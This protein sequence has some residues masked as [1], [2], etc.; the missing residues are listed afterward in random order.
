M[1]KEIW[2]G[3]L[4]GFLYQDDP[5]NG[6]LYIQSPVKAS[7]DNFKIEHNGIINPVSNDDELDFSL[8]INPVKKANGKRVPRTDVT[9]CKK[10]ICNQI[11]N[12]GFSIKDINYEE[13]GYMKGFQYRTKRIITAYAV[14][15][16]GKIVVTD[17]IKANHT[18]L[19]GIGHAKHLGC[20][21]LKIW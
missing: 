15:V 16:F 10:W 11:N 1:V 3:E 4:N 9:D 21:M 7:I 13:L 5:E 18:I 17:S 19:N 14:K 6:C 8:V 12:K 2:P 20:G